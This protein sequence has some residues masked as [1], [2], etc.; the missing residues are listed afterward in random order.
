MG[1]FLVGRYYAFCARTLMHSGHTFP[2]LRAACWARPD[3]HFDI[4]Y[5]Y[6]IFV[7]SSIINNN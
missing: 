4:H 6:Y 5:A 2:F 1:L 3:G 7:L